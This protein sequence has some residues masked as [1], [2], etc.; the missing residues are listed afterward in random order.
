MECSGWRNDG[1]L[2]V[3][4]VDFVFGIT[5]VANKDDVEIRVGMD[6]MYS[7]GMFIIAVTET[8]SYVFSATTVEYFG[9]C[10]CV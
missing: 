6:V 2:N 1:Y 7:K 5:V 4:G 10:V 3:A 8:E 9:H